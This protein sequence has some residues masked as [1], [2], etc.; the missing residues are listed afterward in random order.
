M[1]TG[2]DFSFRSRCYSRKQRYGVSV[3]FQ[4]LVFGVN[5]QELRGTM[6]PRFPCVTPVEESLLSD[7]F[8]AITNYWAEAYLEPCQTSTIERFCENG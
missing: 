1:M 2:R 6:S 5:Q 7:V 3:S 4:V 8:R